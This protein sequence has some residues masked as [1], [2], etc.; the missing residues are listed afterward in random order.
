MSPDTN[1][2]IVMVYEMSPSKR[3]SLSPVTVTVCCVFQFRFVNTKVN[4]V[5]LCPRFEVIDPSDPSLCVRGTF[6][7]R[8]G[9]PN[10]SSVKVAVVPVSLV[11]SVVDEITK[12]T[13]QIVSVQVPP[14]DTEFGVARSLEKAVV[15]VC[16]PHVGVQVS[17]PAPNVG[18]W[19]PTAVEAQSSVDVAAT[20]PMAHAR[21]HVASVVEVR[22]MPLVQGSVAPPVTPVGKAYAAQ[23]FSVQGLVT[24]H[25]GPGRA[26]SK[27]GFPLH[28]ASHVVVQVPS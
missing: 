1:V 28:P 2:P 22:T 17:V 4:A 3:A 13:Q 12:P 7:S 9:C 11:V 10:S 20:Y 19:F 23:L 21:L 18:C 8:V 27:M 15:H 25:A 26:Q 14:Q 6:T 24:V 16:S 5:P